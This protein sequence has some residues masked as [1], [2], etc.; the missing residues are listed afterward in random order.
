MRKLFAAL[1]VTALALGGGMAFAYDEGTEANVKL[2]GAGPGFSPVRVYQLVR[3][4]NQGND[5]ASLGNGDVVIW[6]PV[7]DDGVTIDLVGSHTDISTS[8]DAV[9]GVVVG[10]IPTSDLTGNTVSGDYGQRNWGYIQVYG[11]HT[12]V[13]VDASDIAAGEGLRAS[14]TANRAGATDAPAGEGAGSLG[15]AF[16]AKAGGSN[17]TIEVFIRTQ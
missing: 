8:S 3:Y 2:K 6:D 10:T 16:D 17:G 15:F 11:L 12:G 7:S 4:A 9:A 14:A 1:L 13:K 5:V